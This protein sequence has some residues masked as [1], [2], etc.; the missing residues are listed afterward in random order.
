MGGCAFC[1]AVLGE[2]VVFTT[3]Q[4]RAVVEGRSAGRIACDAESGR[5]LPQSKTLRVAVGYLAVA[6]VVGSWA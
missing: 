5:G 4:H 3:E 1:G 2:N 6:V